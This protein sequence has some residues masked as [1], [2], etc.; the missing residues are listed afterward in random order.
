MTKARQSYQ[1]HET[2]LK[3]ICEERNTLKRELEQHED[4]APTAAQRFRFYQ[5]LRGYV[6]DL[7]ECLDEKV[8]L[9]INIS[10]CRNPC[11]PC[12]ARPILPSHFMTVSTVL[13]VED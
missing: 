8:G 5:E 6:T 12:T 7:V 3:N 13:F 10:A 11:N 1:Q 4:K 2:E 9:Y